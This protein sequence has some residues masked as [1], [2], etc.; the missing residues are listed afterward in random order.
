MKPDV[1]R[2]V[3]VIFP[4]IGDVSPQLFLWI[5]SK[6]KRISLVTLTLSWSKITSYASSQFFG[7]VHNLVRQV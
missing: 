2:Y 5:D 1:V 4:K 6:S 7:V 3:A